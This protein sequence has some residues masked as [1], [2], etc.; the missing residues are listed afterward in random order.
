VGVHA[1]L[2][3]GHFGVVRLQSLD[4][5]V[6]TRLDFSAELYN[7]LDQPVELLMKDLSGHPATL[8]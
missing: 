6:Q 3:L 2:V 7:L 4:H 5:C 1:E 8:L